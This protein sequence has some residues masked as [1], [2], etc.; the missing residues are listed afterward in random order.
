MKK[1][2]L[3]LVTSVTL[4]AGTVAVAPVATIEPVPAKAPSIV[5]LAGITATNNVKDC[6]CHASDQTHFGFGIGADYI[7]SK[8]LGV[9]VRGLTSWQQVAG[10]ANIPVGDFYG[11]VGYGYSFDVE[12]DGFAYGAGFNLTNKL[13]VEVTRLDLDSQTLTNVAGY[14][15]Y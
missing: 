13:A 2:I 7:F 4:M 5:W 10:Y 9:S 8:Y 15:K 14:L 12:E 11:L 3:L 6:K 1:F